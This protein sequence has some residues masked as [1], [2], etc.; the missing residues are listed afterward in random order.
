MYLKIKSV[1]NELTY[2]SYRNKLHHILKVAEKK[3][4]ADLLEANKSNL[5]KT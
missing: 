2:K 3:Y 5:K 4:Y 1:Q